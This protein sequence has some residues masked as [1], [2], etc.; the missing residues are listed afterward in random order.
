MEGGQRGERQKA[1][2][3]EE[4]EEG[5]GEGRKKSP[6]AQALKSFRRAYAFSL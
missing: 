2:G 5:E 4:R 1:G 3:S 6:G